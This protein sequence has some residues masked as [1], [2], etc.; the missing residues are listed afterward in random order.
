[1]VAARVIGYIPLDRGIK[2]KTRISH[3]LDVTRATNDTDRLKRLNAA[4]KIFNHHDKRKHD[5]DVKAGAVAVVCNILRSFS[6]VFVAKSK[7]VQCLCNILLHLCRC[8]EDRAR[9]SFCLDGTSLIVSLLEVVE[10]NYRLGQMGSTKCLVSAQNTI[11]RLISF[12]CVPLDMI[13]RSDELMSSLVSNINGATGRIVMHCSM[14]CLARLSEHT[15]NKQVLLTYPRLLAS[16][17]VGSRHIYGSVREESTIILCNLAWEAKNKSQLAVKTNGWMSMF[18]SAMTEV[19]SSEVSKAYAIKALAYLTS[20]ADNKVLIVQYKDGAVINLLLHLAKDDTLSDK[21]I[22]IN[23]M[24]ILGSVTCRAT[25]SQ[26]GSH[27]GL[28]V[29]LASL[30]CRDDKLAI[31]SAM[32]AKKLATYIRSEDCSHNALLQALVSMSYGTST[33]VLKWTVKAYAG[34]IYP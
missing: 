6:A 3:L 8:S 19:N 2:A 30:A 7:E 27:P 18:V 1:M 5:H 28:L 4:A 15:Q 14:K 31:A 21:N 25:A 24:K 34:E 23:A 32:T 20:E 26:L 10:I 11:D 12:A 29:A 13:K 16:V 22:G 17:E 9:A 33:E